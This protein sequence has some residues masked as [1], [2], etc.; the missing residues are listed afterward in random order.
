[1][2]ADPG[3]GK[4]RRRDAFLLR[5]RV[6]FVHKNQVLAESLGFEEILFNN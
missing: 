4:L 2:S 1:V 3:Q 6:D 5:Q